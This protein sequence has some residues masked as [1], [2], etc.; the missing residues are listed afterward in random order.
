MQR[1]QAVAVHMYIG[2]LKSHVRVNQ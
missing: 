1:L 2:T